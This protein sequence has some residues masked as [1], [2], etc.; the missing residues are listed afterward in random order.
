MVT[1]QSARNTANRENV[2]ITCMPM[3]IAK[4]AKKIARAPPSME[5]RLRG[6]NLRQTETKKAAASRLPTTPASTIRAT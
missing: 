3:P 4:N 2:L 6:L 5:N 1:A